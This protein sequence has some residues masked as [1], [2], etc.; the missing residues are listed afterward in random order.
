MADADIERRLA[1]QGRLAALVI[2]CAI[3]LWLGGQALGGW[4]NWDV[5]VALV[6]D[7]LAM[8]GLIWGL[9]ITFGIYRARRSSRG[10]E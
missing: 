8:G 2:A 7:V 5:R 10:D 9:W 3:L 1:R 4:L 6:M